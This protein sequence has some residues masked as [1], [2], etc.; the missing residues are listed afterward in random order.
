MVP[1]ASNLVHNDKFSS[2]IILVAFFVS[3]EKVKFKQKSIVHL[4]YSYN[5]LN[6]NKMVKNLF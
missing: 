3:L 6:Q 5:E 1:K 4:V 2:L